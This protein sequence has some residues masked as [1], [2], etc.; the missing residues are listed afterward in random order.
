[1]TLSEEIKRYRK[2]NNCSLQEAE[3]AIRRIKFCEKLRESKNIQ[4][5]VDTLINI[6]DY[7]F[8]GYER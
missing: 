4:D 5:I 8:G 2:E 7:E 3:K 1:M 6:L